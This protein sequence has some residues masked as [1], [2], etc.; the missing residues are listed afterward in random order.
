MRKIINLVRIK[1]R[2]NQELRPEFVEKGQRRMN[3][4]NNLDDAALVLWIKV[5]PRDAFP[6]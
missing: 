1:T 6:E 2:I 4:Y 5:C 3:E